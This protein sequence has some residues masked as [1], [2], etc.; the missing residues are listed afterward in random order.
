M[1]A[2]PGLGADGR[3]RSVCP[4]GCYSKSYEATTILVCPRLKKCQLDGTTLLC[5]NIRFKS[6]CATNPGIPACA[7][8]APQSDSGGGGGGDSGDGGSP[9]DSV[10]PPTPGANIDDDVNVVKV[11]ADRARLPGGP[12]HLLDQVRTMGWVT[13]GYGDATVAI[14]ESP[15]ETRMVRAYGKTEWRSAS[16]KIT[17]DHDMIAARAA[18]N[19]KPYWDEFAIT[20]LHEYHHA[21]DMFTCLCGNPHEVRDPPM[22]RQQYEQATDYAATADYGRI[23]ECLPD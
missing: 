4:A 5:A 19:G 21:R 16:A 14:H 13:V 3:R 17:L 10:S 7:P 23:A 8:F 18:S 20:L 1:F 9:A 6:Y 11:C 2:R 15:T 22:T 12:P